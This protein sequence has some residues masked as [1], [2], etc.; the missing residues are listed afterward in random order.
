MYNDLNMKF[1]FYLFSFFVSFISALIG[2]SSCKKEPKL[3]YKLSII[4]PN[5]LFS[6]DSR[7]PTDIILFCK[8]SRSAGSDLFF[9]PTPI[10]VRRLSNNFILDM[11]VL[12]ANAT[13]F[14]S[15]VNQVEAYF[16]KGQGS[17]LP[18]ELISDLPNDYSE[19][20]A[21]RYFLSSIGTRDCV[22]YYSDVP[23]NDSINGC[24]LYSDVDTLKAAI[25]EAIVTRKFRNVIIIYNPMEIQN[26]LVNIQDSTDEFANLVQQADNEF[27]K[28]NYKGAKELYLK[29]KSIKDD[30]YSNK[31]IEIIIRIESPDKKN[32]EKSVHSSQ[33]GKCSLVFSYGKYNGECT[34]GLPC[35]DGTM[36]F[37]EPH[38][39]SEND[40]R[41]AEKG[42]QIAGYWVKGKISHGKWFGRD[43]NLKGKIFGGT[44]ANCD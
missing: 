16:M 31:Q 41:K 30:N 8:P 14:K 1:R 34:N 29:A 28:G 37:F 6:N 40:Y 21:I 36:T 11:K 12:R 15:H 23:K 13:N 44:N 33:R 2:L 17:V 38:E 10:T 39:L 20:D 18:K 27:R 24:R 42:D 35:G 19:V 4:V 32:P 9:M 25:V 3:D 43:G 26:N 7:F 22:F 5:K